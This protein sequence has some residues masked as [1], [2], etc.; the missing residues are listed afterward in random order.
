MKTIQYKVGDWITQHT[1]NRLKCKDN[2]V[3]ITKID[4]LYD[5]STRIWSKDKKGGE[6]STSSENPGW[7]LATNEE[8]LAVGGVPNSLPNEAR[9]IQCLAVSNIRKVNKNGD[10]ATCFHC[11]KIYNITIYEDI[12]IASCEIQRHIFNLTVPEDQK[13]V[14]MLVDINEIYLEEV[15]EFLNSHKYIMY[16][17]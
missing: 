15:I 16:E 7:R 1:L 5:N 14:D 12:V 2:T 17:V 9:N 10:L 4:K 13:I 6:T 11:G 8:I 3:Q